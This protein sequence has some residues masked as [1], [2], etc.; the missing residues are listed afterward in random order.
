[1]MLGVKWK[2][3]KVWLCSIASFNPE[4]T[5]TAWLFHAWQPVFSVDPANAVAVGSGLNEGK[6]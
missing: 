5:A 6:K 1:M 4:P 3:W 2:G